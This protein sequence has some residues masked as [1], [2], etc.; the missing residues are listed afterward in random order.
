MPLAVQ[1]AMHSFHLIF[2]PI[3]HS[4]TDQSPVQ[5]KMWSYEEV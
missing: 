3:T 2:F 5:I 1:D 4:D